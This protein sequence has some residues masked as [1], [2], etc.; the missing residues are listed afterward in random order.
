[1]KKPRQMNLSG[2]LFFCCT[3]PAPTRCGVTASKWLEALNLLVHLTGFEPMTPA[4]G[5]QYS[6]Q[7]SYRCNAGAII[8]IWPACVHAGD[9]MISNRR[10]SPDNQL[11][12]L[13]TFTP[14]RSYA[15]P[16][17]T[18][19]DPRAFFF[20]N[21]LLSFNPVVPRIRLRFQT[22]SLLLLQTPRARRQIPRRRSRSR[23]PHS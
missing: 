8:L 5:G 17:S 23:R 12:R 2:A 6:I 14:L 4:F 20:S 16:I 15:C 13:R 11:S 7:L 9:P 1:M 21:A 19:P 3:H 18:P 22:P 10:T